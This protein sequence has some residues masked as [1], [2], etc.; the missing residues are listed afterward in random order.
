MISTILT[1]RRR[2]FC[3]LEFTFPPR[4]FHELGENGH[5]LN[6]V[7]KYRRSGVLTGGLL[8]SQISK[9]CNLSRVKAKSE[10]YYLT[11]HQTRKLIVAR[12]EVTNNYYLTV[13][14]QRCKEANKFYY[15]YLLA[16]K[17]FCKK[18]HYLLLTSQ[19]TI[20]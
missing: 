7:T 11:P 18:Y 8:S 5:H 2:S 17:I 4:A 16:N 19:P 10:N 13:G 6:L 3:Q 14:P 15:Y 20:K 1:Y 12:K 9:L